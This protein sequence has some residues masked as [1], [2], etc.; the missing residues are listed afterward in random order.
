MN[1]IVEYAR[2]HQ[3][4][5]VPGMADIGP[6]LPTPQK[7]IRDFKMVASDLGIHFTAKDPKGAVIEAFTPW[8]NVQICTFAPA[9]EA[10]KPA[11]VKDKFEAA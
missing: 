8:V 10:A 5:Y 6:R 1:R 11:L 4:V 7:I 2:L 3:S 9:A